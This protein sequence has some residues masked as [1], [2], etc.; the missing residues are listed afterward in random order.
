[1][2]EI[3][4][5]CLAILSMFGYYVQAAVT[6]KGP[7]ENWASHIAGPFAANRLTLEIAA[8]CTPSV[9]MFATAKEEDCRP[10]GGF[11][12]LVWP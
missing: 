8:E 4:N 6:G 9:A 1:M 10:Q 5:G 2:T 3:T 11:K 12:G 7:V